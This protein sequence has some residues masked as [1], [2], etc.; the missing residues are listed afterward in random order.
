M[1][2]SFM[3]ISVYTLITENAPSD[4]IISPIAILAGSHFAVAWHRAILLNQKHPKIIRFG[5][6]EIYY[7]LFL[8]A[9]NFGWAGI[10]ALNRHSPDGIRIGANRRRPPP[11]ME[12]ISLCGHPTAP[13]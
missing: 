6:A 4:L 3:S 7:A 13:I 8:L 1:F 12:E 5:R 11:P 10:D 2:L 9:L